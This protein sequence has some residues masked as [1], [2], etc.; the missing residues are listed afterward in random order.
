MVGVDVLPQQGDFA[1]ALTGKAFRNVAN[2]IDQQ[3]DAYELLTARAG[4]RAPDD[5]WSITVGGT[6]LLDQT[7]YM[8]G[9]ENQ[10]RSYQPG[11]RFYAT[12]ETRF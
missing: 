5:R 6:N 2:T 7:Y 8:L 10:A 11:R 4:Y 9:I 3:S 12:L 1:D